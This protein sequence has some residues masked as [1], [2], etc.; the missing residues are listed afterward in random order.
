MDAVK[1]QLKNG[2]EQHEGIVRTSMYCHDC[3]KDFIAVVDYS[4][5]GN[6]EVICPHCGHQHCRTIKN[7][8]VTED[9]WSSRDNNIIRDGA[10]RLW[11]SDSLKMKT[12]STSKFLRDKWLNHG[13]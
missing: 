7:G 6:H 10:E 13:K 2:A 3:G 12:S 4:I 8:V 9:R 1:R 5:E 11:T